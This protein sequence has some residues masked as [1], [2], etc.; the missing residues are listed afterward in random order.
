VEGP[1]A[2]RPTTYFIHEWDDTYAEVSISHSLDSAADLLVLAYDV[3]V[4][5]GRCHAY[6]IADP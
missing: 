6:L 3:G 2:G 1:G 5:L 4:Q